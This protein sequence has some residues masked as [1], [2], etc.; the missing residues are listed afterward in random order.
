MSYREC[1]E[2]TKKQVDLII[3]HQ[4]EIEHFTETVD[5]YMSVVDEIDSGTDNYITN[6]FNIISLHIRAL[7]HLVSAV[8]IRDSAVFNPYRHNNN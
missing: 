1:A 5:R 8:N 7:G 2:D 3:S 4:K 6:L